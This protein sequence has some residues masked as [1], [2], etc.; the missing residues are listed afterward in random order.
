L[1]AVDENVFIFYT[2]SVENISTGFLLL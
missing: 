2:T 1:A